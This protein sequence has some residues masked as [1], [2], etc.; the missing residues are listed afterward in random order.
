[1]LLQKNGVNT[2]LVASDPAALEAAVLSRM[3]NMVLGRTVYSA[4]A[5]LLKGYVGCSEQELSSL[6][7]G[8]FYVNSINMARPIKAQIKLAQS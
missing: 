2:V 1:M 5:M 4:D 3:G 8:E 7:Q 6:S